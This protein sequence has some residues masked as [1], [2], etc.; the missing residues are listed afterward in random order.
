MVINL[1]LFLHWHTAPEM[2]KGFLGESHQALS[3]GAIPFHEKGLGSRQ[4][5]LHCG[6]QPSSLVG[7]CRSNPNKPGGKPGDN[8]VYRV[9][10]ANSKMAGPKAD[11]S[12]LKYSVA[13][14]AGTSEK[15]YAKFLWRQSSR[16]EEE[17]T[18]HLAHLF[19]SLLLCLRHSSF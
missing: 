6:C 9:A 12:E 18:E 19:N 16:K 8:W 2:E 5:S 4:R 14:S 17:D 7:H 11:C 13:P 15:S 10:Q 1:V 3:S